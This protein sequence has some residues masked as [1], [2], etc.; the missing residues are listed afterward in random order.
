MEDKAKNKI[1][2]VNF[3]ILILHKIQL[4]KRLTMNF[5]KKKMNYRIIQLNNLKVKKLLTKLKTMRT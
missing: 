5:M 2:K 4:K 3:H 1:K